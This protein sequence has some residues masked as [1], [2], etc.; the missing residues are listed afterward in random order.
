MIERVA[1]LKLL[2]EYSN[3]EARD[4]ISRQALAALAPLAGVREVRVGVPA[5]AASLASWD[6][7]ITVSFASPADCERYRAD[8]AHRRFVEDYLAPRS[9]VRKAW[10]FRTTSS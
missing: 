2:P 8:P 10:T 9:D 3:D 6:L 7:A 5:D 4:E 1:L